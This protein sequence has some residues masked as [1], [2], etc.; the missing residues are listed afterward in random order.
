MRD[1][2]VLRPWENKRDGL[3]F[4]FMLKPSGFWTFGRLSV[5]E[6]LMLQR[7]RFWL[8]IKEELLQSKMSLAR[9]TVP[10]IIQGAKCRPEDHKGCSKGL[11]VLERE[12]IAT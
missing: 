2:S 12:Q 11:S 6:G 9:N 5:E 4:I 3:L 7:S 1:I 8:S 10:H